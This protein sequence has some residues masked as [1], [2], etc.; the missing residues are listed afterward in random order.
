M[1]P[2]KVTVLVLN[3]NGEKCLRACLSSLIELT[4]YVNYDVIVVDNGSTDSS[5]EYVKNKLRNIGV[6]SL[7][8][9][10]GYARGNN[11]GI[12][13][14]L[15]K[16]NPSYV[17][18]LNND[19]RIIQN[20]WLSRMILAAQTDRSIAVVGPKL[21]R[22]GGARQF[23]A[24]YFTPLERVFYWGDETRQVHWVSG[25]CLMIS[26]NVL[27]RL[28]AFD[29]RYS[30]YFYEETEYCIRCLQNGYKVL[31][32]PTAKLVHLGQQSLRRLEDSATI[33]NWC[34]NETLFFLTNLPR[35]YLVSILRKDLGEAILKK[36]F[37]ATIRGYLDG[38]RLA[39]REP[40]IWRPS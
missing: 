23:Y 15:E 4:D 33:Y 13:Y 37:A 12:K 18:L 14:A 8:R 10:Y 21:L 40:L 34:K 38:Y 2:P 1:N 39:K 24:G 30:P 32:V 7:D 25:A 11:E 22:P 29:E 17:L 16:H 5:A 3:W 27:V 9:N 28:G 31:T 26:A 36:Q 35:C 19:T 6:L 20:D